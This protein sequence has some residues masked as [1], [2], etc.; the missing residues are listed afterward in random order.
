LPNIENSTVTIFLFLFK[1]FAEK[2]P[3][4]NSSQPLLLQIIECHVDKFDFPVG[5]LILSLAPPVIK[6]VSCMI[7]EPLNLRGAVTVDFQGI[8]PPSYYAYVKPLRQDVAGLTDVGELVF[9]PVLN[10]SF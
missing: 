4:R 6:N 8:T 9:F 5:V 1:L 2:V 10:P 7:F 3:C